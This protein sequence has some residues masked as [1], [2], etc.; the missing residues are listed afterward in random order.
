[1]I[2]CSKAVV[3]V[4]ARRRN[5]ILTTLLILILSAVLDPLC[6]RPVPEEPEAAAAAVGV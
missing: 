4:A 5:K 1:M 3:N 6:R 2:K